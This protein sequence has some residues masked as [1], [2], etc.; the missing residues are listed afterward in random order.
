MSHKHY[1]HMNPKNFKIHIYTSEA[2]TIVARSHS[3]SESIRPVDLQTLLIRSMLEDGRRSAVTWAMTLLNDGLRWS[4]VEVRRS[5]Q[6]K[7]DRNSL[8]QVCRSLG[9]NSLKE[10]GRRS[11]G[12]GESKPEAR[13]T[14]RVL[15]EGRRSAQVIGII[16]LLAGGRSFITRLWM[17]TADLVL[18]GGFICIVTMAD[19]LPTNTEF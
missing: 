18:R 11:A 2:E 12:R 19:E 7:G 15:L 6:C 13:R 8:Q 3:G 5:T 17:S 1:E 10:E 9:L 16:D 14:P 4:A